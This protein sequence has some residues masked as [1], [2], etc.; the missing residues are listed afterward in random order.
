M[1][2][3]FYGRFGDL[4]EP[5]EPRP[6]PGRDAPLQARPVPPPR[7]GADPPR[8]RRGTCHLRAAV[9]AVPA[10]LRRARG[11]AAVGS[12][13]RACSSGTRTRCSPPT[14]TRGV[15]H[16]VRD[17]RDRYEASLALWP[18]G[19]G[20]AGGAAARWNYST[21]LAARNL[22]RYPGRYLV[23]RFEDIDPG[24]G[25]DGPRGLR[26]RGRAVRRGDARD[27]GS[28]NA[29]ARCSVREPR[30]PAAKGP[31]RSR[32]GSSAATAGAIAPRGARVPAAADPAG[33]APARVRAG[34]GAARGGR[35]GAVRG[36]RVAAPDGPDGRLAWR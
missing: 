1:E 27:A 21:R 6:L 34:A 26:V 23:I 25:G 10:A 29:P 14:P 15:I 36:L 30:T 16:M 31:R 18:D 33:D 24:T 8:V 28:P 20:R 32:S 11:Q 35:V 17:P 5:G 19:K 22:R 3:Y 2:T 12:P 13:D 7:R 4:A 9:R